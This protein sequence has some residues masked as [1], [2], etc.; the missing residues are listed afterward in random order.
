MHDSLKTAEKQQEVRE[1]L[2]GK[3]NISV[4]DGK[5]QNIWVTKFYGICPYQMAKFLPCAYSL[6]Y[7][8]TDEI[9]RMDLYSLIAP[10]CNTYTLSLLEH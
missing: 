6:L 9:P 4:C 1:Y 7:C 8:I 10:K 5:N 2:G 3:W